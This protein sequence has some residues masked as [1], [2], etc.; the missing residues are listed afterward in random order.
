MEKLNNITLKCKNF[1]CFSEDESGFNQIKP[2]NVII[3]RNSSGKSSLID[4]IEFVCNPK[5][6]DNN[7]FGNN[8]KEPIIIFEDILE[9]E[10]IKKVFQPNTSEGPI[11]GIHWDFGK[12]IVGRKLKWSFKFNS[13]SSGIKTQFLSLNPPIDN[14]KSIIDTN[15]FNKLLENLPNSKRNPFNGF[16]F[17]R[18]CSERDIQKEQKMYRQSISSHGDGAT[19]TLVNYLTHFKLDNNIVEKDILSDLNKIMQDDAFFIN[20][21]PQEYEHDGNNQYF[22][23]IFLEEKN[24][25]YIA[26]SQSGSGIKTILLVLCFL[27]ILPLL[28]PNNK[29]NGYVYAFEELENNLHPALQRRLFYFL[30]E[31][32]INNNVIFFLSTHSNIAIDIFSKDP[33]AQILHIIHD[34]GK[35]VSLPSFSFS[36]YFKI[37]DDMDFRASDIFQSNCVIW[38]EG[39]SDKIYINKWIDIWTNGEIK[40]GFHYQ[41]VFYGGKILS[42]H[43]IQANNDNDEFINLLKVNRHCI[44]IMDSDKTSADDQINKTKERIVEE[45][46]STDGV[47]WVTIGKEIENYIP[48][49]TFKNYNVNLNAI[50][51]FQSFSDYSN[52]MK[53]KDLNINY[54]KVQF[55]NQIKNSFTKDHLERHLDLQKMLNTICS[56]IKEWN[57]I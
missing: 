29:K 21:K 53:K 12:K 41:C 2:I 34:N 28:N 24:K 7:I 19:Q 56:K 40:D 45:I 31:Y 26:L 52:L 42:H 30:Q 51:Q 17:L 25:G 3:G 9:E 16:Y 44:V 1:K 35:S 5:E 39:P 49:D 37:L 14:D 23:E 38:L 8:G 32:A 10:Q 54:D 4:L 48:E 13:K 36:D 33:Y 20:I 47:A 15:A 6:L 57:R 11:R 27:H 55:A 22:W 43:T 18:L 50:G 46:K